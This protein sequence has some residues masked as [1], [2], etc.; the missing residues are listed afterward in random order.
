[1]K[2]RDITK[3]K[4]IFS[5]GRR[6]CVYHLESLFRARKGAIHNPRMNVNIPIAYSCDEA[7]CRQSPAAGISNPR[8]T[9]YVYTWLSSSDAAKKPSG[10]HNMDTMPNSFL[11]KKKTRERMYQRSMISSRCDLLAIAI[12]CERMTRSR[13]LFREESV[14]V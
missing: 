13:R 8:I 1:M 3:I 11:I 10:T 7:V 6:S 12:Q 9:S 2:G 14:T 4:L 5:V